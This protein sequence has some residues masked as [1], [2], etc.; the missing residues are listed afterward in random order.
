MGRRTDTSLVIDR[1]LDG[2]L[3]LGAVGLSIAAPNSLVALEKP[4]SKFLT[5]REKQREAARVAKYLKQ[6]KLV[7]V[8]PQENGRYLVTISDKGASRARL[9]QLERLEIPKTEW[10]KKWRL[11]M[12]DIPEKH[13]TIRDYISKQLRLVGFKQLQRSVFI[14]PYPVDEFIALIKELFPEVEN[15][16][17]YL[18][19]EDLDHHNKLVN[20]FKPIL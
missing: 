8:S 18:T 2:L 17:V 11:V 19:A 14:Y 5:G 3:M 6:Q 16:F 1:L 7:T 10:D 15:N 13:K 4:L 12:F 9:V 20:Q